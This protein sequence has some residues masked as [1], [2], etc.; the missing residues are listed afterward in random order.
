MNTEVAHYSFR[1][2][3]LERIPLV[4]LFGAFGASTGSL[5]ITARVLRVLF[6]GRLKLKR[7]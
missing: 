4:S 7:A 2:V 5:W 1:F 3:S 6:V